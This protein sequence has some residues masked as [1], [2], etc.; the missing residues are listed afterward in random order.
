MY[1]LFLDRRI[2][3]ISA[4]RSCSIEILRTQVMKDTLPQVVL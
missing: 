1:E 3:Y 4:D 2:M